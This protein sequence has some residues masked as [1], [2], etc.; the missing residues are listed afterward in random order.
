LNF[1]ANLLRVGDERAD[2]RTAIIFRDETGRRSEWSYAQLR[3]AVAEVA[4]GLREAGIEA[5]DRVAGFLPNNPEAVVAMLAATSIGA[6]WSSC[7]PDFGVNGVLDRFGQI[8]PKILFATDG[9]RYGGKRVETLAT[10]ADISRRL[11]GLERV[12]IVPF[13]DESPDLSALAGAALW[14]D[15]AVEGQTLSFTVLPFDHPVYIVYSS[16][17]TGVP[18]CIVHGAGGTLIQHLKEHVLHTD[19]GPEDRFFFFTTCGW[20]MWN[21]LVSGLA[22]GAAIVLYDGSPFQP[23][24]GALWRMADEEGITIFGASAKYFMAIEKSSCV[25]VEECGLATVRTLLSTGSPLAPSSY[26]FIYSRIKSD[27]QLA[28]I[29]GGTELLGCFALGNPLRPVYRGEL[30]CFGLGMAVEIFDDAGR[31]LPPGEKGELACT[32]PFP[33]MP[34]GFWNDAGG[35][36][37][38]GAYFERFAGA[39]A[40]GDYA[41]RTA[42]DGLIIHGRSDAVLNPG[43]VRIGTAELYREVEA[44]PEIVE[45]IAIGQAWRGDTRIVLFV[46]LR[47]GTDLDRGLRDTIRQAIRAK[48]SPRH[49]PAK[50]LAVPEIPMTRSG[51]IVELAVRSIV[52]GEPVRNIDALVNPEALEYFRDRAELSA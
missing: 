10:V 36:R 20:M 1:A 6:I 42:H 11:D 17:T 9:Y 34:V 46:V 24:A 18:K 29:S 15:F 43:G 12:V 39:W 4:A 44:F 50:I 40:H 41:E 25:P 33:S 47:Q 26:D 52:N 38:A 13:L 21:W 31:A 37:Y 30:Q 49:V 19:V 14:R 22:S 16:G 7:S 35:E 51:K 23:D 5:G 8:R 45:S 2:D 48:V 3:R 28:S 27:V 32:Q